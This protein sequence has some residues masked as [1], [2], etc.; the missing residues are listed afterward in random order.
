VVLNEDHLPVG[1]DQRTRSNN[2]WLLLFVKQPS[3]VKVGK[4]H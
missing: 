3:I 4:S 1:I 2:E